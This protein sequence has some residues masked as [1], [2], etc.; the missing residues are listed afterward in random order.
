MEV[1]AELVWTEE[2]L[3]L[4]LELEQRELLSEQEP[5]MVAE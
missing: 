2:Q 4:G 1:V 5:A 3:L